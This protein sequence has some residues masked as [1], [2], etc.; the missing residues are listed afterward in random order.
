MVAS[1]TVADRRNGCGG[2]PG[3]TESQP[4]PGNRDEDGIDAEGIVTIHA[5]EDADIL[6]IVGTL[7][8]LFA[9]VVLVG[10]AAAAVRRYVFT[11]PGLVFTPRK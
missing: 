2:R 1:G 8:D 4:Q 6:A 9:I 10:L 3:T 11:P 7:V 5:S